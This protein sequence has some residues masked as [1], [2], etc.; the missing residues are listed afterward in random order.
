MLKLQDISFS[1]A[2]NDEWLPIFRHTSCQL[3]SLGLYVIEGKNGIGKTTLF[4]LIAHEVHPQSGRLTWMNQ[5][6]FDVSWMR[7]HRLL[8]PYLTVKEHWQLFKDQVHPHQWDSSL[9][10]NL[11]ES[12]HMDSLR[13]QRVATLSGGEQ[14]RLQ[15]MMAIMTPAPIYLFDEPTTALDTPLKHVLIHWINQRAQQSLVLVITHDP[16]IFQSTTHGVISMINMQ[17]QVDFVQ[18]ISIHQVH[19]IKPK[20]RPLGTKVSVMTTPQI[21]W[22]ITSW[23]P[24]LG[25]VIVLG[26][27]WFHR[28]FTLTAF[29][30][31]VGQP[32]TLFVQVH[33]RHRESIDGTPFEWVHYR[34]LRQE[35]QVTLTTYIDDTL[36]LPNYAHLMGG[37]HNMEGHVWV[38]TPY[39]DRTIEDPVIYSSHPL[40]SKTWT[41]D[42]Q[43]PDDSTLP[44]ALKPQ[45]NSFLLPESRTLFFPYFW[46][47]EF[48]MDQ[49]RNVY[50][51]DSY[52]WV[53]HSPKFDYQTYQ[54]IRTIEK[55]S[56]LVF[57]HPLLTQLRLVDE[58]YPLLQGL[59]MTFGTIF[60][61]AWWFMDAFMI[62]RRWIANIKLRE[63]LK[64]FPRGQNHYKTLWYRWLRMEWFFFVLIVGSIWMFLFFIT[65]RV[66]IPWNIQMDA[67]II[68]GWL[69][70]NG[71][72]RLTW[73][74]ILNHHHD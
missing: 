47:K 40:I 4:K 65:R 34:E 62:E 53:V 32:Q 24:Y 16:T 18:P 64:Q 5:T 61:L 21:P 6:S 28:F 37:T 1:Y 2:T 23:I 29:Q 63:W 60:L 13:H 9:E 52:W 31:L 39:D 74:D 38:L 27:L 58:S 73:F 8:L 11:F 17:C 10:H 68:V 67:W 57:F 51:T 35:E 70:A 41:V 20:K 25:I 14:Q 30:G 7:Q 15:F 12:L 45:S 55:Q 59:L 26:L 56:S 42:P 48:W 71:L 46:L 43:R 3:P 72:Y 66:N 44:I 22:S 19:P 54:T 36:F 49:G 69:I 33:M 50:G